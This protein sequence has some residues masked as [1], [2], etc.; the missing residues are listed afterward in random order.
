MCI[1][2]CNKMIMFPNWL[3][4]VVLKANHLLQPLLSHK[5]VGLVLAIHKAILLTYFVALLLL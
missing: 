5:L 4:T 2:P 3:N 1:I